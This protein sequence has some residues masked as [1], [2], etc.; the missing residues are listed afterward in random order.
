MDKADKQCIKVVAR[1]RPYNNI[2]KEIQ[3]IYPNKSEIVSFNDNDDKTV[4]LV[5]EFH[6]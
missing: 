4:R 1:F 2:E 5:E 3:E 6:T